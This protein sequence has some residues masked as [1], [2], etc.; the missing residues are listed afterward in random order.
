MEGGDAE[1]GTPRPPN[2]VFCTE[3]RRHLIDALIA[4]PP[5]LAATFFYYFTTG[6][7]CRGRKRR[8]RLCHGSDKPNLYTHFLRT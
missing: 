2:G 8:R 6:A 3:S 1:P 4:N 7:R 5:A